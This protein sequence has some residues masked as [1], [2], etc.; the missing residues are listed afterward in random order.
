MRRTMLTVPAAGLFAAAALTACGGDDTASDG[1]VNVVAAFYP[2]AFAAEQ[3]GGEDVTVT[4][5][6]PAGQEPHDIELDPSDIARVEEADYIVYLEGFI[7]ELDT[8]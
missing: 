8:A 3:V 1:G 4:N 2:L 5:L 6:T 7:P